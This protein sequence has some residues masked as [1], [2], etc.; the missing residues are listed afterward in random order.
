MIS[1]WDCND[2]KYLHRVQLKILF[3][4]SGFPFYDLNCFIE[5]DVNFK[6]SRSYDLYAYVSVISLMITRNIINSSCN[7]HMHA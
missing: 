4:M 7:I 6:S 1:S 3:S 2:P 5:E